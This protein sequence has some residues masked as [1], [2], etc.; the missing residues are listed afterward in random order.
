MRATTPGVSRTSGRPWARL[1]ACAVLALSAPLSG[2]AA[3]A[4]E[5]TYSGSLQFATGKYLFTER[6]NSA[7][8]FTGLSV[9]SGR[10]R[11]SANL[12]LIY[13]S[14]PWVSY[15][16]GGGVPTGGPQGGAVGD[17]LRRRGGGGPGMGMD[18][19]SGLSG[20]LASGAA[21]GAE[22]A[23]PHLPG[24]RLPRAMSSRQSL[25]LPDT[26]SFDQVGVGDPTFR[27]GVDLV[28][29]DR[30]AVSVTLSGEV[31]APLA[32]PARGFGTG[33]WDGGAALSVGGRVGSTV[34]F[35]EVGYWVL[36][37]LPDLP[38]ENPVSYSVGLGHR[39][40]DR[41]TLLASLSG[42]SRIVA[43]TDPPLDLGGALGYRLGEGR[44]LSLGVTIGL[45]ESSPDVSVSAGWT[46]TL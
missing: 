4:Q 24:L 35:G 13:Q 10:V 38:L 15:T 41:L 23:M 27:V 8:L 7:Y 40:G 2:G 26:A 32:D 12:P 46:A 43:G 21:T 25:T 5:I 18:A 44:S 11:L 6:T 29:A 14:T 20:A 19:R 34:L 36:G 39:L 1:A 31:K 28:P 33:E 9:R 22:A 17:S 16:S 45:S 3:R 30:G 42:Y 37:D